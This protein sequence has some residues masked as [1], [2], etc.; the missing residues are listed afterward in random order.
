MLSCRNLDQVLRLVA[1]HYHLMIETFDLRY[2]RVGAGVGEAL[3]TPLT[4]M[5]IETLHFY[6]EMLAMAHH[7]QVR[8]FL[9]G[10]TPAYDIHLSMPEPPH[11]ARY[12]ALAPVRFHFD[13]RALPGVRV[14]MGA[15]LL[16]RPLPLANPRVVADVDERCAAIG[17]PPPSGAE[18]WGD[19]VRMMLR[20]TQG[21]R[22]T[23]DDLARRVSL[24]ARTIDRH[25][26][27][28]G[29]QF[30]DLAQQVRFERACELLSSPSATVAQVAADLGFSDAANFS[31]AF[32]RE[33]GM[34][35]G[36]YQRRGVAGDEAR[37]RG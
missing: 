33:V 35:P 28:E 34:T 2:R 37:A 15:D 3:Y 11:I 32:R 27:K 22:V 29:L 8:L 20:Q 16:D 12:R 14:L 25:L 5:P 24:S 7:N 31:R 6:L 23:L 4:S 26:K 1:R 30:R 21:E 36:E 10:D 9:A 13:A 19:F 17:Q 18:G